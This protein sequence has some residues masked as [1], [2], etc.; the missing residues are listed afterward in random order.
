MQLGQISTAVLYW[1]CPWW[2]LLIWS[3]CHMD[4]VKSLFS[5]LKLVSILER[6]FEVGKCTDFWC[7][8][9]CVHTCW[10]VGLCPGRGQKVLWIS[11]SWK[12][13]HTLLAVSVLSSELGPS[14]FSKY[15][16]GWA[17]APVLNTVFFIQLLPI[18]LVFI[19]IFK[20][21]GFYSDE[22]DL[23]LWRPLDGILFRIGWWQSP[24]MSSDVC[25]PPF[26]SNTVWTW[27]VE[28]EW[29]EHSLILTG[30]PFMCLWLGKPFW[31]WVGASIKPVVTNK[32][33]S[34]GWD[35]HFSHPVAG[36]HG[37]RLS[38]FCK[39]CVRCV[40]AKPPFIQLT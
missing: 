22:L 21:S 2:C 1:Q 19:N 12:C 38:L 29:E 24:Q 27:E 15:S 20:L 7:L 10:C 37:V 31:P 39:F 11:W 32:E 6:F 40:E 16:S 13:R 28:R 34:E 14:L 35:S 36:R 4:S 9:L 18:A 26:R 5:L 17:I 30:V 33:W 23:F 25:L 8:V 3:I